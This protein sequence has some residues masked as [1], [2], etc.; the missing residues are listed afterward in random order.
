MTESTDLFSDGP[1]LLF[2]EVEDVTRNTA[3]VSRNFTIDT[4]A[5][6]LV[7][8]EPANGTYINANQETFTVAG[9][10]DADHVLVLYD[11]RR[12]VSVVLGS[13]SIN[14]SSSYLSDGTSF[15]ILVVA[16]DD[17]DNQNTT[18]VIVTRDISVNRP[19]IKTPDPATTTMI[20]AMSAPA[21]R[22]A[23]TSQEEVVVLSVLDVFNQTR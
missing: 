10:S 18:S 13:F 12:N 11:M 9:Q 5:P 17:V 2:L 3:L 20:N 22:I 14:L 16:E 7:L 1:V 4:T 6:Q 8:T 23:G 15:A 19:I 21:V